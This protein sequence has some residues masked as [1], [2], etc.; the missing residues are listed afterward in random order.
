M[1]PSSRKTV[2]QAAQRYP[3]AGWN[4]SDPDL[5]KG[6]SS[7]RSHRGQAPVFG[8]TPGPKIVARERVISQVTKPATPINAEKKAT[9]IGESSEVKK[10]RATVATPAAW[11]VTIMTVRKPLEYFRSLVT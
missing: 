2:Q 6:L 1:P 9:E 8:T 4:K 3:I 11:I 5:T 10:P 7:G